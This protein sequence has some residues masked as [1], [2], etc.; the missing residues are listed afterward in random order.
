MVFARIMGLFMMAPIFNRKEITQIIK[1]ALAL[2]ITVITTLVIKPQPIPA[3][4]SIMMG[5]M[6]NFACGAMIGYIA[7]CV[8]QAVAAG[9]DMINMQM[10]LSSAM[11]LD[12]TTRSQTSI[13][14]NY[15]SLL[16]LIVFIGAGGAYWL[17]DSF[18][19][20]FDVFPMYSSLLPLAKIISMDY[21]ILITSQILFFGM[22]LAAPVLLATLGQ[23]II[24]GIISKTAPQ[25][26][27]FQLSFLFKPVMGALIMVW[28]LPMLINVIH[29]YITSY[30]HIF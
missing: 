28:I 1:I 29:D 18:I 10:G 24:L 12:P 30:A 2:I 20:S 19:R 22:Q 27:V 14:G 17:I 8:L 15:F 26:N 3:D 13:L 25:V 6:L 4:T 21:L 5:V 7:N 9:G 23:D 11:V 16:A